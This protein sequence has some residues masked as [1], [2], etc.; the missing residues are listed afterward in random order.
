[1][2]LRIVL[3]EDKGLLRV[4]QTEFFEDVLALGTIGLFYA[5]MPTLVLSLIAA[6][7]LNLLAMKSSTSAILAGSLVGLSFGAIFSVGDISGNW[8]LAVSFTL[9]GAICGWIYWLIA[10]RRTLSNRHAIEA[11]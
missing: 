2:A 3:L 11:G 1:M 6:G 4:F 5:C 8:H 7:L 9:S 10:I